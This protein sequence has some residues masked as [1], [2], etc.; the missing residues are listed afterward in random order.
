MEGRE[1]PPSS[2]RFYGV[3]CVGEDRR[4]QP[5]FLETVMKLSED[6]VENHCCISQV[7]C[8]CWGMTR[9]GPALV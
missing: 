1:G 4:L 5:F 9:R 7:T 6:M 2:R 3:L 8:V